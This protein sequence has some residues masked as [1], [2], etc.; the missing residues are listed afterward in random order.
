[1]VQ[2]L[3]GLLLASLISVSWPA[4]TGMADETRTV[5]PGTAVRVEGKAADPASPAVTLILGERDAHVTPVKHGFAKTAGANIDVTQPSPDTVVITATGLCLAGGHPICPSRASLLFELSQCLEIVMQKPELKQARLSI[6][7]RMVGLLRS[8]WK[9]TASVSDVH[10]AVSAGPVSLLALS[11]AGQS[12]TGCRNASLNNGE[13]PLT[14][15]VGPGKYT[16]HE[17][18]EISVHHPLCALPLRA[19]TAELAPDPALNPIWIDVKEPF[20]GADKKSLGVQIILRVVEEP[21]PA[22][23]DSKPEAPPPPRP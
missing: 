8:H 6:E 1:M 23:G 12:V 4:A 5:A 16:L 2:K 15:L 9:G 14:A 3:P 13:G 19:A 18:F 20:H 10:A 21:A 11:L 17:T 22:N 7:G